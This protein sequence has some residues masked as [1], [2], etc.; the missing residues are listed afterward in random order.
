M[1]K[2]RGVSD[3]SRDCGIDSMWPVCKEQ[4]MLKKTTELLYIQNKVSYV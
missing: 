4:Q 1:F 2:F 3:I